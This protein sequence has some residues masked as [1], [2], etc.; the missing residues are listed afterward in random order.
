M[1]RIPPMGEQRIQL[2]RASDGVQL[3]YARS[4]SGPPLLTTGPWLTHLEFDWPSPAWRPWFDL[5]GTHHS[6]YRHDSRGTGLSDRTPADLTLDRLVSDLAQ[7]IDAAGLD[8]VALLGM[9]HRA[10]VAIEYAAR[11]PERVSRLLIYGGCARGHAHQEP[12]S[13]QK[14]RALIELIRIGWHSDIDAFHRIFA[15]LLM[16]DAPDD[17]IEWQIQSQRRSTTPERAAQ[18]LD[19]A[20]R[21]D[22]THRLRHVKAATLVLHSRTDAVMP[23]NEGRHLAARIPGATF[24]EL[25]SANHLLPMSD[26]AWARFQQAVGHF[27]GWVQEKPA[28]QH[29][30][31]GHC[32]PQ[33]HPLLAHLTTREMDV[34][35]RVALAESNKEIAARLSISPKTVRNH[36]TVVFDK[37]QLTSRSAAIVFARE[38]RVHQSG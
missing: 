24:V 34:L 29:Q 22:V 1:D 31:A 2:V 13:R 8:R 38:H 35:R 18:L 26:P 20:S 17:H 33:D 30:A 36:L 21:F 14:I 37:L 11:Y 16:P 9:S 23:A 7:V 28:A 32:A 10:P 27:L 3:A 12:E 15:D 6:L 25:D 19:S 4:G 5:L